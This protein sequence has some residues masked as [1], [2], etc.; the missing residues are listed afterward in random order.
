MENDDFD[1]DET[2]STQDEMENQYNI[3]QDDLDYM[4]KYCCIEKKDLT[5]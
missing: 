3:I 2:D 4:T 1:D 5:V